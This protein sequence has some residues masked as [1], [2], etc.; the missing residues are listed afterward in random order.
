MKRFDINDVVIHAEILEALWTFRAKWHGCKV[1]EAT[2]ACEESRVLL[3]DIESKGSLEVYLNIIDKLLAKIGCISTEYINFQ[4]RGI[5]TKLLTEVIKCF[6][7]SDMDE[8]YGFITASDE[9]QTPGLRNWYRK[10]GFDILPLKSDCIHSDSDCIPP[11][12]VA[13]IIMQKLQ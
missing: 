11:D 4:R 13:K 5:G 9:Q 7:K 1:G 12:S 6:H 8:L 2:C 3:S 10:K